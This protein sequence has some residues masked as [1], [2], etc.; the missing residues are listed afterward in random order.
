[1]IELERLHLR[2]TEDTANP[3]AMLPRVSGRARVR[4][5]KTVPGRAWLSDYADYQARYR[6]LEGQGL[7][8]AAALHDCFGYVIDEELPT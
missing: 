2:L 6:Q 5:E 8:V 1:M 4:I 3:F 7:D